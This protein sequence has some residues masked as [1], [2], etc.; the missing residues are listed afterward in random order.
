MSRPYRALKRRKSDRADWERQ[1]EA[2][3]QRLCSR[4]ELQAQLQRHEALRQEGR[5]RQVKLFPIWRRHREQA[6][7]IARLCERLP[8]LR[9]LPFR[10]LVALSRWLG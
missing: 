6:Q 8:F 7:R 2:L 5:L 10:A 3:A 9:R 4:E 1:V